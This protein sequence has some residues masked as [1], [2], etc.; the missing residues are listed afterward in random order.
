MW[1]WGLWGVGG[2]VHGLGAT[3]VGRG[4]R[5]GGDSS[6]WRTCSVGWGPSK[7]GRAGTARRQLEHCSGER[8]SSAGSWH[9]GARLCCHPTC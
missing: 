3:W 1:G 9:W 5:E 2:G 6:L 8:G 7:A 4:V